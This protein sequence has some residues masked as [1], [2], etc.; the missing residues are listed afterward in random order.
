MGIAAWT[1]V[2]YG[3]Y[4][5]WTMV[6]YGAGHRCAG[7][8]L[9][10]DSVFGAPCAMM[11]G[12][13]GVVVMVVAGEEVALVSDGRDFDAAG[14]VGIAAAAAAALDVDVVDDVV[15]GGCGLQDTG[16]TE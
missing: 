9:W 12:G 1:T 5:A 10:N 14:V 3:V 11:A 13:T 4:A 15:C 7:D 16:G 8:C 2:V 6:V